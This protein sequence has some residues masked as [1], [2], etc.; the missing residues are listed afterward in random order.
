ME[1]TFPSL[2]KVGKIIPKKISTFPEL[3]RIYLVEYR[4][5]YAH[6][7]LKKYISMPPPENSAWIRPW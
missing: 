4:N 6:P 3:I 7:T 2:A 1:Q 5:K